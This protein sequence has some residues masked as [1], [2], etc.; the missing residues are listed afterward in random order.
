MPG[1][2]LSFAKKGEDEDSLNPL[3]LSHGE[4]SKGPKASLKKQ[5][6]FQC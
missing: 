3:H 4:A 2:R 5:D 6:R 1:G